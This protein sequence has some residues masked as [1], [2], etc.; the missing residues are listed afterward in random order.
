MKIE[1]SGYA[2]VRADVRTV[3]DLRTLLRFL[4]DNKVTDAAELD[5]GSEYVYVS[6]TEDAKAEFIECGEHIPPDLKFDV[7][8]NTHQHQIPETYEE[9]LELRLEHPARF[10]WP[11]IDKYGDLS[12]PE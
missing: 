1:M 4:D 6:V 3:E 10:D 7:I 2:Y 11:A 8:L 5:W 9:A 12:R